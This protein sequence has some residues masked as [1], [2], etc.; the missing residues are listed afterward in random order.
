[1]ESTPVVTAD[2]IIEIALIR[3]AAEGLRDFTSFLR[4]LQILDDKIPLI[5]KSVN[6]L[7]A[8]PGRTLADLFDF[9]GELSSYTGHQYLQFYN[10]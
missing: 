6:D 3:R 8:G 5:E 2:I 10:S 1:M 7:V 9:T 4:D